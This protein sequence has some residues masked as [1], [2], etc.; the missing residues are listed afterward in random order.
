MTDCKKLAPV[1]VETGRSTFCR[2]REAAWR[3]GRRCSFKGLKA[4][5]RPS[6]LFFGGGIGFSSLFFPL[7]P[8][9]C[10][11]FCPS[12]LQGLTCPFALS[13]PGKA[14]LGHHLLQMPPEVLWPN[15]ISP[16]V[17]LLTRA[18]A[19]WAAT[20]CHFLEAL[21]PSVPRGTDCSLS[22]VMVCLL[23]SYYRL[24][25][26]PCLISPSFSVDS[27]HHL[28]KLPALQCFSQG[29]LLGS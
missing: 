4:D 17:L 5:R 10:S 24:P 22:S 16:S 21:S 3:S 18:S 19:T 15:V 29:L 13:V 8:L 20:H 1:T 9:Y 6:S 14:P 7:R 27:W 11:L 12:C 26:L 2:V 28:P 23:S 25:S